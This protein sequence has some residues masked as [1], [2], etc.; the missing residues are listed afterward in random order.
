MFSKFTES[1]RK[2]LI[3]A[4]KEMNELKHP[5]IGS[6]HLVLA[7]LKNKNS[8]LAKKLKGYNL[9]YDE[10][11]K[12]IITILG[13]GNDQ[14]EWFLYTPLLKKVI[15]DSIIESRELNSDVTVE[16]LFSSLIQEGE[17]IAIRIM[18]SMGIDLDEL[19]EQFSNKTHNKR[20]KNKKKFM[21]DEFGYDLN[22]K[23]CK[24]ELDPVIGREEEIER[25]IEILCRRSK[26]N[27][28]LIGEAGVGKTAIVEELSKRI[29]NGNVPQQLKGK[30]IVSLSMA[31]LVS[32]TKYRGEFEERVNKIMKEIEDDS[33]VIIFI[34]EI[35]TL[36]GAGGAEGAIDASN[37]LKPILARGQIK[38]IGATTTEEF[39][40][41]IEDDRALSRRFQNVFIEEPNIQQ[42]KDILSKLKPVYEAFHNVHISDEVINIIVELSDKYIYDRKQPDKSIDILDESCSKAAT[43]KN[44]QNRNLKAYQESLKEILEEKNK[45]I[46]DHNFLEASQLRKK[47][48]YIED[49]IYKLEKSITNKQRCLEVGKD[50]V[51]KVIKQKTKIPI[52]EIEGEATKK[53]IKLKEELSKRIIGQT[54]AIDVLYKI[55][56]KIKL[57]FKDKSKPIS[58][59]FVGPTGVGKT[60]MVKEFSRLFLGDDQLITIDMSEY[61]EEH[62]ISK[63]IGSPPGYVGYSN[64][65][66]VL[67]QIKDKPYSVLL[68]DEIEK[69]HPSVINLF[70]QILDEGRIKDSKG[71][72]VRF[73]NTIIIMTSNVGFSKNSI[74]FNYNNIEVVESKLK[75]FLSLEIINRIDDVVVFERLTE[76][77]IG[78][79]ISNKL[80]DKILTHT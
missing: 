42:T 16:L 74:G 63:I 44:K 76:K 41:Y 27:P 1:A 75:E 14:A 30:R 37:I 33:R 19:I 49:K 43:S 34:D 66:N 11:K 15:E 5:Y 78:T 2:V 55:S 77:D 4:K 21:I 45:A 38:I 6:E 68:L 69:A 59:L 32:G 29:A 20:G 47:E 17:G 61:K 40:K 51:A 56:K 65:N 72:I 7:M 50:V 52:F 36:V 60:L 67:E 70:L 35:H 80:R 57:G 9:E 23:A 53:L 12:E 3:D 62:T 39:K 54:K 46:I 26:N 8:K 31:S 58:L 79:I 73:D 24:N 71:N 25:I 22:K 18:I 13:I 48:N 10:F 28:L 64:K